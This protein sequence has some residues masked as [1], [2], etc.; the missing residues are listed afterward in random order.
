MLILAG[1]AAGYGTYGAI[2][3]F[4]AAA[5]VMAVVAATWV[6]PERVVSG[7]P[8][9]A[10]E[11]VAFQVQVIG[12]TL[13]T[14]Y[15]INVDLLAVKALSSADPAVAD[16]FAGYYTAAQKLAQVPLAVVVALA[17]LM[18]SYVASEHDRAREIVRQ[19]MRALLL[20]MVA[21]AVL[22]A[23]N[24]HETLLLVFPTIGRTLAAAGDPQNAATGALA[25]LALGYVPCA[26]FLTSTTLITASGRPGLAAAIAAATLVVAWIAVR[27][28]TPAQG[29]TGAALGVTLAWILGLAG[30]AIAMARRFGALVRPASALRIGIAGIAVGLLARAVATDGVLLLLEYVLLTLVFAG[31]LIAIRELRI[32]E[33]RGALR[34]LRA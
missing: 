12:V 15:V 3:G 31:I 4:V 6:R 24:A 5:A 20:L 10:R 8:P 27:V 32:E 17:Y 19:G 18:F 11:I 33:I 22:L 9:S 21:P 23:A 16:R 30:C 34:R 7:T 29:P 2:G 1:A 28:L 14:Q 26:M 25:V 13:A